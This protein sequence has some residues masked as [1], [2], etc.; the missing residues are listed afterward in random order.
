MMLEF[1]K[2][3]LLP[4]SEDEERGGEFNH[5][6]KIQIATCALFVE[7][8]KAD[9]DFTDVERSKIISIMKNT[10]SINEE[11]VKELIELSE[12]KVNQSVSVYEFT[13]VIN[14]NFSKSEKFDLLA[15]LWRLVYVDDSLNRYED[16]LM[17]K[18]GTL[19]NLEHSDL[20]SAKLLA[21]QEKEK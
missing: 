21:K 19:L 8:A 6:K 1:L 15:N 9:D 4:G 13:T 12:S 5:E 17:R 10:F 3:I 16:G 2:K 14:N 7:L 20:I 11:Y 18:L